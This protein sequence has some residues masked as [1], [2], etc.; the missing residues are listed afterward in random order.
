MKT[1]S[2]II[3]AIFKMRRLIFVILLAFLVSSCGQSEKKNEAISQIDEHSQID[4]QIDE[5]S[6]NQ[7]EKPVL[8]QCPTEGDIQIVNQRDQTIVVNSPSQQLAVIPTQKTCHVSLSQS[9]EIQM[10]EWAS[11]DEKSEN[12]G[13]KEKGVRKFLKGA[14]S[15]WTIAQKQ[16]KVPFKNIH[17]HFLVV[18][19]DSPT[20]EQIGV[21]EKSDRFMDLPQG[22]YRL[23]FSKIDPA[24][25]ESLSVYPKSG[26]QML[27]AN[28]RKATPIVIGPPMAR[29]DIKNTSDKVIQIRV[30]IDGKS[31]L[32]KNQDGQSKLNPDQAGIFLIHLESLD[33]DDVEFLITLEDGTVK[34]RTNAYQIKYGSKISQLIFKNDISDSDGRI[35][36]QFPTPDPPSFEKMSKTSLQI[37]WAQNPLSKQYKLSRSTDRT[38]GFSEIYVGTDDSYEDKGLAK[39]Q[40]YF[41]KLSMTDNK[42]WKH[43]QVV[44]FMV[45][46]ETP[47]ITS[48]QA[49]GRYTI[50]V[51]WE[52]V[53]HAETYQLYHENLRS[54]IAH[55]RVYQGTSTTV[56]DT[57][58][59]KH[60]EY[61]YQIE[62]CTSKFGCSDLS[63]LH[64]AVGKTTGART[65]L[66][67]DHG[68]I[69]PDTGQ[70][71]SYTKTKGEDSDYEGYKK[72][73]KNN[74]DGTITDHNTGLV[75]QKRS[76]KKNYKE[77]VNYCRNLK[78]GER[79]DWRL[80]SIFELHTLVDRGASPSATAID[81]MFSVK[82]R[83]YFSKNEV[84]GYPHLIHGLYFRKEKSDD[85]AL[86]YVAG[87]SIDLPK[88]EKV[89][90][91]QSS[92]RC[93]SGAETPFS[94]RKHKN[95]EYWITDGRTGL[96]WFN[97]QSTSSWRDK[98]GISIVSDKR[99]Y[100][101]MHGKVYWEDAIK[102]CEELNITGKKDWR[103]TNILT[104][105]KDWRLPN[106]LELNSLVD[107][108]SQRK[109]TRLNTDHDSITKNDLLP[110]VFD[111]Y[112]REFWSSTSYDSNKAWVLSFFTGESSTHD[113]KDK[114]NEERPD[115]QKKASKYSYLCVR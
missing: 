26:Y 73:F 18:H 111:T 72:S 22:S 92:F 14:K 114:S 45:G 12:H 88:K 40:M 49:V 64:Q 57:G 65:V 34:A 39:G 71:K 89:K 102:A 94:V 60:K 29:L 8:A 77:A 15:K 69:L 74:G 35:A 10:L 54:R 28:L 50:Q 23:F 33:S 84:N 103:V 91:Y 9:E 75:W 83:K 100:K 104:G 107:Y 68:F 96:I 48:V 82:G 66:A 56:I 76:S 98:Y 59:K 3:Y 61:Y 62:A 44:N 55:T 112:Q 30:L 81:S 109:T 110:E 99:M 2:I 11:V 58:L 25:Q 17:S 5:Q 36:S 16:A 53:T 78:L 21:I 105:K 97:F 87:E 101:F 38:G 93:V 41:Y 43:S 7:P 19:K 95:K 79:D 32:L 13:Q 113:K 90:K 51:T 27:P 106:I 31:I 4:S 63:L 46:L 42:V 1:L 67:G 86:E 24:T 47:Q 6:E 70:E 20:G 115:H 85:E 52:A 108:H 37:S 80:P